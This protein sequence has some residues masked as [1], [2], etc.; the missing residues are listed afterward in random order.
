MSRNPPKV[1]GYVWDWFVEVYGGI[2]L[3]FAELAAWAELRNIPLEP[4]EALLLSKL[5]RMSDG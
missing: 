4:W 5:S 2:P 3:T 1:L